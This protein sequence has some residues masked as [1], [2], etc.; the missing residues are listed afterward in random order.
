[1]NHRVEDVDPDL[2]R[3][4]V[5]A[6]VE[7][8]SIVDGEALLPE[9]LPYG[10]GIRVKGESDTTELQQRIVLVERAALGDVEED[11]S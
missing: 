6:G 1:M 5:V 3:G 11:G 7:N 8:M 9:T 10:K 4:V 2:G